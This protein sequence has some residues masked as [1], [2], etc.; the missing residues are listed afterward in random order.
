M[1]NET[2]KRSSLSTTWL[3][4]IAIFSM[5]FGAG[6]VIFPLKIGIYSGDQIHFAM[7]GL[8]VT[9]IGGP[10]LGLVTATLFQ[11]NCLKFFCRPGKVIG[12]VFITISLFLL[13]P[14]AVIP[15]CFVV[16]HASFTALFGSISIL[17]F[18]IILGA[19]TLFA[20]LRES[21]LLPILGKFCSP[22]L[23]LSLICIIAVGIATGDPLTAN[24]L[25]ALDAFTSGLHEGFDTMDLIAALFFSSSIWTLLLIR[26][27]KN[28]EEKV[29][30]AAISAGMIAGV[31]LGVVYIG[32]GLAT[33][34]H[35]SELSHSPPEQLMSHLAMLTLGPI[36]GN[37]ANIAIALACFTTIISLTQTISHLCCLEFF[38]K[39][40]AYPQCLFLMTCITVVFSNLGFSNISSLIHPVIAV[41]Y[42]AIIALTIC[43]LL[44]KKYGYRPVKI[45]VYGTLIL[46]ILSHLLPM[47]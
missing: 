4:G 15:R 41:C 19:I 45:A 40:I 6:N 9:A 35:A 26:L 47:T 39:R 28:N 12:L 30:H 29:S 25:S 7:A 36:W 42:P 21:L 43:N 34:F 23:L 3:A 14:F 2:M 11:G 37:I 44:Y 46:S 24:K 1:K 38:P 20:C 8:L 16:A 5:F 22:L 27:G 31:L 32:L 17:T 18:S 33:A 10:L 13:G